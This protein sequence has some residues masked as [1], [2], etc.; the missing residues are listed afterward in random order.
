M[1]RTPIFSSQS[2]GDRHVVGLCWANPT[3]A[4]RCVR[5]VVLALCVSLSSGCAVWNGIFSNHLKDRGPRGKVDVSN[6]PD[7][8]PKNEPRSRYGNPGSYVV[9]GQRYTPLKSA[10]G[11]NEKG[12]ASWYGEAFHGKRTSSGEEYDM[13]AMTAAHKTLPLPTYLEVVN[14]TNNKRAIVRVNDR[15]PFHDGRILDLS[16]VA[17]RKLGVDAQGTSSVAIR[18]INPDDFA[19]NQAYAHTAAPAAAPAALTAPNPQRSGAGAAPVSSPY[20]EAEARARLAILAAAP[21]AAKGSTPAAIAPAAVKMA[22]GD[23]LAFFLQLGAFSE[24]KNAERLKIQIA[25][26]LQQNVAI[27]SVETRGHEVFRVQVGPLPNIA[28]ADQVA[29]RLALLGIHDHQVVYD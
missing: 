4:Q 2:G 19:P 9:F 11:Y 20:A 12:V 10:E 21:M 8:V 18:A 1:R 7:A 3:Y 26:T 25:G 22:K 13:Y 5:L 14:L 15:G 29:S 16:Y 23:N 6:I 27:R 28:M 24:R 17:A